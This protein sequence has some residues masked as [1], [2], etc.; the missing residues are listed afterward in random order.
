[1]KE[2]RLMEAGLQERQCRLIQG[3]EQDGWRSKWNDVTCNVTD[4]GVLDKRQS[5]RMKIQKN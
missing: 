5:G 2:Y 1:M 4:N 3:K